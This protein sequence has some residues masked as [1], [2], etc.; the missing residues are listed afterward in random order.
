MDGGVTDYGADK[1]LAITASSLLE[2]TVANA[3]SGWGPD[4]TP[5]TTEAIAYL[6]GWVLLAPSGSIWDGTL[7]A[8]QKRWYAS[9]ST[10]AVWAPS[11]GNAF[12]ALTV[13]DTLAP[14]GYTPY[15]LLFRLAAETTEVITPEG[16]LML[17]EGQNLVEVG[18]GLVWKERG[19]ILSDNPKYSW[20]NAINAG[21]EYRLKNK[22][23]RLHAAYKNEQKDPS[24]RLMSLTFN[25]EL[26][27]YAEID[28]MNKDTS[29]IYSLSYFKLD[30]SPAVPILGSVAKNE[31]AVLTDLVTEVK[32]LGARPISVS[33]PAVGPVNL[34]LAGYANLLPNSSALLGNAG[35]TTF[36]TAPVPSTAYGERGAYWAFPGTTGNHTAASQLVA[37]QAG[38]VHTLAVDFYTWGMVAADA[39]LRV[40]IVDPATQTVIAAYVVADAN[41]GWHRKTVT[42]S[43][44]AGVANG[45]FIVRMISYNRGNGEAVVSRIMLNVGPVAAPWNDESSGLLLDLRQVHKL[46]QNSGTVLAIPPPFDINTLVATGFYNGTQLTN[47]PLGAGGLNAWWYIEVLNHSAQPGVYAIQKAYLLNDVNSKPTFYMRVL[48]GGAWAAWSADL[49][50]SGVDAKNGI[51]SAINAKGGAALTTDTWAV[52]ASKI[53]AGSTRRATGTITASSG[54][55]TAFTTETGGSVSFPYVLINMALIPFTAAKIEI[56]IDD[57]L[58]ASTPT[59]CRR[60]DFYHASATEYGN[61]AFQSYKLRLFMGSGSVFYPVSVLGK[62]YTWVAYEG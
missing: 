42:F 50:Q 21:N 16:S 13:P 54:A 52:L 36:G 29:A 23:V 18:T 51:V 28:N 24:W 62:V 1:Y 57:V 26:Y 22:T 39:Q 60:A 32:E 11:A 45:R 6:L 19:T 15:E 38:I 2:I 12:T 59:V 46:T 49:F 20:L 41:K 35:W 8:N 4:Y 40:D 5:S 55:T 10:G 30:A 48:A 3:D 25:G 31:R 44:P 17:H 58:V 43:P 33:A 47:N 56:F 9:Q 53:G 61:C 37:M 27:A 34:D 14:D 7:A